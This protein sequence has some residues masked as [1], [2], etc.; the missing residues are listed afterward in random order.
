MNYIDK[1]DFIIGI[2]ADDT[3]ENLLDAWCKW[4][5]N[6]Y[7]EYNFT[8]ADITNWDLNKHYTTLTEEQI[9]EPL[10]IDEFFET[11][12]PK[13]DAQK[14]VK[15]LID[16]GFTVFICT[17][18]HFGTIKAKMEHMLLKYFPYLTWDDIIL[19]KR[20]SLLKLN[21]LVD[22]YPKNLI[23]GD[24]VKIL[25]DT[26]HNRYIDDKQYNLLRYNNWE[27]IYNC[28]NKLYEEQNAAIQ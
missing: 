23:H 2:D 16:D 18:S 10:F 14:Y 6:K 9:F 27:D 20:K 4:L 11:I 26:A 3:I 1:K 15:K 22:D 8:A 28:I 12:T 5:N 21:V 17:N 19:I 13:P 25:F 24:Y 7:P